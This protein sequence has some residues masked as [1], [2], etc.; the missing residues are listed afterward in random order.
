MSILYVCRDCGSTNLSMRVWQKINTSE[1]C[2]DVDEMAYCHN[3]EEYVRFDQVKC[4][5]H[6]IVTDED[7]EKYTFVSHSGG[8]HI[9]V[10]RNGKFYNLHLDDVQI[11]E[12]ID[13]RR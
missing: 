8:N 3:C 7:G 5:E 12:K 6:L 9:T 10:K 1:I 13:H 11:S 4:S 2:E